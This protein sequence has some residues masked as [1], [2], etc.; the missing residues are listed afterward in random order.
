MDERR[1]LLL[2]LLEQAGSASAASAVSAVSAVG[3]VSG[4]GATNVDSVAAHPAGCDIAVVG[5]A[6]RY[7]LAETPEELWTNL[8]A[9]RDCVGSVP[10]GRWS[11]HDVGRR[12][13]FIRD[14]DMFDP[15]FFGI[16]PAEAEEMDPQERVFLETAWATLED[17]GYPPARLARDNPIGVFVGVMNSDYAWM[18]GEATASG[19]RTDAHSHHWSVANRVS[20]TL[21]LRGPSLAVD[22]ACSASLTAVHL[23][24]ESLR[25]G[26]CTAAL[27]GGVNLILHPMHLR[28]LADRGMLAADDR[29]KSFGRG[30][31]GFADGEG[32]GAVLLKPLSRALVDSDRVYGVLKGSAINSG[33]KTGGYTVP[34]PSAQSELI[35]AALCRAGVDPRTVS[36]VEA[37]GTGTALGDPIEIAGLREAFSL[38]PD[39]AEQAV[40]D[41]DTAEPDRAD[42]GRCAV[43]SV[44]SA[45]GHLESAA[46]IAGL[47]SVLMQMRHATIAPSLHSA[48]P[49]PEI[50]LAGAPF[51]VPQ[52]PTPWVRPR[53]RGRDGAVV[54]VPRRAGVSSFGG[55]GANAHLIVEEYRP[56]ATPRAADGPQLIVVSARD[57]DRLRAYA[58][59]LATALPARTG[60]T[61]SAPQERVGAEPSALPGVADS[62][63]V[64]NLPGVASLGECQALAAAVLA[65]APEELDPDADLADYGLGPAERAS[66]AERLR[67]TYGRDVGVDGLSLRAIA[68]PGPGPHG[69]RSGDDGR[70][71]GGGLGGGGLGGGGLGGAGST[72][73]DRI[74]RVSSC[75]PTWRTRCRSGGRPWRPGWRSSPATWTRCAT[76]Y[77]VSPR[78][79]RTRRSGRPRCRPGGKRPARGG[80]CWSWPSTHAICPL[81]RDAGWMVPRWI[82]TGCTA[83]THRAGSGCR[84]TRSPGSGTGS[85][86]CR[87]GRT[88]RPLRPRRWAI[89]DP[90]GCRPDPPLRP[91]RRVRG[92]GSRSSPRPRRPG[93]RRA[94]PTTTPATTSG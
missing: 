5:V 71:G 80:H 61:P 9:G 70:L 53:L 52:E 13:G 82:G 56:S 29:C 12:A 33:G 15:L 45:I 85:R 2:T 84:H 43:G 91:R 62:P 25:R 94:S 78:A 11:G 38:A 66:L 28:T 93:W 46:G 86:H 39:T 27:A 21:D 18:G 10:P 20:Y 72:A 60:A 87:S 68:A 7:P 3:P 4:V 16:S 75:S 47:T 34:S 77:A 24:C 73:A 58:A 81:W 76:A 14:A 37:H 51:F 64:A 31:D 40:S 44:K 30:A 32:V 41:P 26:E 49:N 65:V 55:G 6:G 35:R 83:P 17:A 36:Y 8:A 79:G 88:R 89:T 74:F 1:R 50:D 22:T 48:E 19:A 67:L 92:S 69:S 23:A 90:C 54:E 57:V 63:G 42:P 59:K